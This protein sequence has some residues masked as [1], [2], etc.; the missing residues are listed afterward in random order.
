MCTDEQAT[1]SLCVGVGPWLV[2]RRYAGWRELCISVYLASNAV[3]ISSSECS[4]AVSSSCSAQFVAEVRSSTGATSLHAS[5]WYMN[6]AFVDCSIACLVSRLVHASLRAVVV[7]TC[8]VQ[9][10][11]GDS[12]R[13]LGLAVLVKTCPPAAS[14]QQQQDT[15]LHYRV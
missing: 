10:I 13:S 8:H 7:S 1:R 9:L 11:R 2:M 6:A 15:N 5:A 4:S 14:I 12:T 3:T